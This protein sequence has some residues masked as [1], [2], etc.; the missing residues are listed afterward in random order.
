MK[1]TATNLNSWLMWATADL[2]RSE[3][4]RITEEI[5][6][7][8]AEAALHYEENG[9]SPED[10]ARRALEDLGDPYVARARF[11]KVCY[12]ER[13]EDRLERLMRRSWW[14]LPFG[15][16]YLIVGPVAAVLSLQGSFRPN[17]NGGVNL[18]MG[19]QFDATKLTATEI[20]VLASIPFLYGLLLLAEVPIKRWLGRR[21]PKLAVP[22]IQLFVLL[23]A[24]P[25][26]STAIYQVVSSTAALVQGQII[27][28]I[29]SGPLVVWLAY[30]W[31]STQGPLT[32]KSLRRL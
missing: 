27:T 23:I 3:R 32:L 7:H 9:S 10:A 5:A 19:W 8:H 14:T 2:A 31:L 6:A 16:L 17:S 18:S 22:L 21:F 28:F 29:S 20:S 24:A 25:N 1:H 12:T 4:A 13:D 26:V 30:R 11:L 15:V